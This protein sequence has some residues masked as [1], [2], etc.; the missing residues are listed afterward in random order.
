MA[1]I[2]A[3][4][5]HNRFQNRNSI[6]D[7]NSS[8]S[9]ERKMGNNSTELKSMS[10][11]TLKSEMT[12]SMDDAT[13]CGHSLHGINLSTL[14]TNKHYSIV[15]GIEITNLTNNRLTKPKTKTYSG[16]IST[17]AVSVRPGHKEAMIAHK[18]GY[19]MTGSSGIVSWLI[20]NYERRLVIVWKSPYFR[21][22]SVGICLTTVGNETHNDSWF[23]I[24]RNNQKCKKQLKYKFST[25]DDT[26]DEIMIDDGDFQVFCSMGTSS[27][28][29][30]KITLRPT[31]TQDQSFTGPQ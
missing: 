1:S 16:Y 7:S 9:D 23:N 30:V 26:S 10:P 20:Q 15:V 19:T 31:T 2:G 29:E 25:F 14:M 21:S 3:Y 11:V 4:S 8:D 12:K 28:P 13:D 5:R 17:P 27:K 22:N 24:I 18:H 6:E